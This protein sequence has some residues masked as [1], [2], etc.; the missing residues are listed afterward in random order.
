MGYRVHSQIGW[1]KLKTLA[2]GAK[3]ASQALW[4]R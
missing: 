1:A 2:E 4:N 3:L